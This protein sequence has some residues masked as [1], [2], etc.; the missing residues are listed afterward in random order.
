MSG[1][2]L[3]APKDLYHSR[4]VFSKTFYF[5]NAAGA[6]ILAVNPATGAPI[7]SGVGE[8]LH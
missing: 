8:F 7:N 2:H 6:V 5:N 4:T 1:S 3:G